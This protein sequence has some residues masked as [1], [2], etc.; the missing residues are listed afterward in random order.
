MVKPALR[1][2]AV[3]HVQSVQGVSERSACRAL[4]VA[5]ATQ[6][7]ASTKN[8]VVELVARMKRLAAARP[9]A[10]Y[11]TLGRLLL[12]EGV[13]INHKRIY[14]LYREDGLTIRIKRRRRLAASPRESLPTVTRAG[15]RWAMDFVFDRTSDGHRFRILTSSTHS[16]VAHPEL[17]SSGASVDSTSRV[18]S[19]A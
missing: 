9:R 17:S 3:R 6:R 5:R 12:R 7:Y 10:G 8:L 11:R 13:R 1:R 16:R 19:T 2:Q 4:G 14:R 18:F 15:Q